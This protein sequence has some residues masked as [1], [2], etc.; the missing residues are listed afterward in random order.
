MVTQGALGSYLIFM[1]KVL[2]TSE[3][4]CEGKGCS[5]A[6]L[7]SDRSV[8]VVSWKSASEKGLVQ[9]FYL[10]HCRVMLPFQISRVSSFAVILA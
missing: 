9:P 2:A 3:C 4:R 8:L 7:M 5:R 6:R 1:I 10:R